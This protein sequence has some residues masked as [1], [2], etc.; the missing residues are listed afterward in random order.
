MSKKRTESAS[1]HS[2]LM[3][4]DT[5]SESEGHIEMTSLSYT[6][7]APN[8]EGRWRAE[9]SKHIRYDKGE[10]AESLEVRRVPRKD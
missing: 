9:G 10:E 6:F 2:T 1:S 5:V 3:G 4:F 8:E 7:G